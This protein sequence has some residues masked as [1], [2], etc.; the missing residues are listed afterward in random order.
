MKGRANPASTAPLVVIESPYAGDVKGNVAYARRAMLH[1]LS[2]GEYP[3]AS[4]LLYTQVLEDTVPERRK[5]GIDAGL[6][7]AAHCDLAAIYCDRG[8][9][10]G[11]VG[12]IAE[13][14]KRVWYWLDNKSNSV[15]S[16][17][18]FRLIDPPEIRQ[19]T[20]EDIRK[21]YPSA[22]IESYFG[23]CV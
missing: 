18:V 16:N 13:H 8:I 14:G 22:V 3:I 23:V 11:M 9:S 19:I 6:A 2:L 4:H 17:I 10:K 20:Y 1:S 5:L 7:W 12:A 21:A 15:K